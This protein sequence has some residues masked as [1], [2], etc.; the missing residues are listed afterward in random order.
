MLVE[1][2]EGRS[3]VGQRELVGDQRFDGRGMTADEVGGGDELV[4][5][6]QL[7]PR[8]SSSL[9]GSTPG[10]I[11]ADA[12]V[13]PTTTMRPPWPAASIAVSRISARPVVSMITWVPSGSR[14]T[15]VASRESPSGASA[16]NPH[17]AHQ[18]A[19][20][21]D[22]IDDQHLGAT[23]GSSE[24]RGRPDRTRPEHDDPL[25]G[26]DPAA[27][28]SVDGDCDGLDERRLACGQGWCCDEVGR[29]HGVVLL[30]GAVVVDPDD[31]QVDAHV[32]PSLTA[33][34]AAAAREHRPHGDAVARLER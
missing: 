21:E 22:W 4:Q 20:R 24:G 19:P 10:W 7:V 5:P 16:A 15:M 34:A 8:M 32:R 33:R 9:S 25:T 29:R 30:E 1:F 3:G 17:G 26:G 2:P 6:E 14:S 28:H 13:R 12:P 11:G 31:P 23:I 18:V 27:V